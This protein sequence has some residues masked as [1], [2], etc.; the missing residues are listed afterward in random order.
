MDGPGLRPAKTGEGGLQSHE[1]QHHRRRAGGLVF[2]D[3]PGRVQMAGRSPEAAPHH[4]GPAAG[5]GSTP[6]SGETRPLRAMRRRVRPCSYLVRGSKSGQGSLGPVS[7]FPRTTPR[8]RGRQQVVAGGGEEVRDGFF[9]ER[10]LQ[11]EGWRRPWPWAR[12]TRLQP[13]ER[14]DAAGPR[15]TR[16]WIGIRS[17]RTTGAVSA[18]RWLRSASASVR[19]RRTPPVCANTERTSW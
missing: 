16:A 14:L 17:G 11:P 1:G 10:D 13:D 3:P 9:V 6:P 4:T 5:G 15:R 8:Q 18:I 12:R 7:G 19:R 2:P